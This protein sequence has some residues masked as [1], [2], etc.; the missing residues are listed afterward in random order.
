MRNQKIFSII[1]QLIVFTN[2]TF[3]VQGAKRSERL[4]M[5]F[6]CVTFNRRTS[7]TPHSSALQ[8][9]I[10]SSFRLFDLCHRNFVHFQSRRWRR[11]GRTPTEDNVENGQ[12]YMAEAFGPLYTEG[13][14]IRCQNSFFSKPKKRQNFGDNFSFSYFLCKKLEKIFFSS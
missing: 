1:S 11:T 13:I 14:R 4:N 5:H 2:L 3:S 7:G 6:C 9:C 12:N 8:K 10:F